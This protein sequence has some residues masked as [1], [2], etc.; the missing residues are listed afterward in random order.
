MRKSQLQV[1]SLSIDKTLVQLSSGSPWILGIL[2]PQANVLGIY[3]K[4]ISD[5]KP[6]QVVLSSHGGQ[7]TYEKEI[8]D[9]KNREG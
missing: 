5:L 1:Y 7:L 9:K 2:R 6:G 4:E 8:C 3:E